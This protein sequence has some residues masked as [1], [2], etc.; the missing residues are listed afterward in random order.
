M[1]VRVYKKI[2][3]KLLEQEHIIRLPENIFLDVR[4]YISSYSENNKRVSTIDH[5]QNGCNI[6][7]KNEC[8]NL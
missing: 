1:N 5:L 3:R 6:I 7:T 4:N 8:V 2:Y